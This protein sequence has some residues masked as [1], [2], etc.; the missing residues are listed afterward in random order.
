MNQLYNNPN[1]VPAT[2]KVSPN[3]ASFAQHRN[4]KFIRGDEIPNGYNSAY[5]PPNNYLYDSMSPKNNQFMHAGSF[6]MP[7]NNLN[8]EI[9]QTTQNNS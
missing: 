5:T 1:F 9:P 3:S 6:T 7:P 2:Q 8:I 4:S